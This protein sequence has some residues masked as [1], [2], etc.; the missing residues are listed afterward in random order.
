MPKVSVIMPVY[1]NAPYLQEAVSSIL[2]QSF[3]D[4]EFLIFDDC[5]TDGSSEILASIRDPR[6]RLIRNPYNRGLI[7]N[8]NEGLNMAQG[9]YI[10]RMD[11]DD[12]SL[13]DRI[14]LQVQFMDA[15]P[16]VGICGTA[17]HVLGEAQPK[18][19]PLSH[20][21]IQAW[22]LFHCCLHHPTVIM[23]NSIMQQHYI[24]YD[25]NYPHA[26]DY[27]LWNRVAS[28]VQMANLP[29]VLLYYRRH[30]G[31]V[32]SQHVHIQN[33]S[34]KRVRIRELNNLGL[35]PTEEEFGVHMRFVE[36]GINPHDPANYYPAWAWAQKLLY[37]NSVGNRY[38][39]EAL[40][41]ALSR[42]ISQLPY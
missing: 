7:A 1:N 16:A 21:E 19:N 14:M 26:E 33:D 30:S 6:V 10:V 4:F 2:H 34:A 11:G 18:V 31:Q 40:N 25:A 27:E 28:Y 35:Y 36:F 38:N 23:R 20:E 42:C 41:T 37:Q 39:Q 29:Q 15:N 32:S 9:E 17:F 13:P 3:R 8:L 22:L 5:S 24:R 12:V